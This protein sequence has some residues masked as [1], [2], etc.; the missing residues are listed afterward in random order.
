MEAHLTGSQITH[1]I[2]AVRQDKTDSNFVTRLIIENEIIPKLLSGDVTRKRIQEICD[3]PVTSGVSDRTPSK[4]WLLKLFDQALAISPD[5]EIM[6]IQPS[7][8]RK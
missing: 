2:N 8:V 6:A 1:L 7:S 5:A 3:E 4:E